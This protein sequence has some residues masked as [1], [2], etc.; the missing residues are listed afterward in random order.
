MPIDEYNPS[1]LCAS[2]GHTFASLREIR[3]LKKTNPAISVL[4]YGACTVQD[5]EMIVGQTEVCKFAINTFKVKPICS[6]DNVTYTGAFAILCSA[7]NTPKDKSKYTIIFLKFQRC[8]QYSKNNSSR[9]FFL[10][11]HLLLF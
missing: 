5:V 8:L 11:L 3:C 2:N 4:H 10:S 7:K 9:I 1:P 6:S